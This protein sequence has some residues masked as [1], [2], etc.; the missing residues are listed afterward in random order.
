MCLAGKPIS[1]AVP[2]TFGKKGTDMSKRT[3]LTYDA[4]NVGLMR[5]ESKAEGK[6]EAEREIGNLLVDV[7]GLRDNYPDV[8]TE[9]TRYPKPSE[10][11]VYGRQ[12]GVSYVN[13]ELREG[14]VQFIADVRRVSS[15]DE[16]NAARE[17]LFPNGRDRDA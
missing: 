11:W 6:R 1:I 9:E 5:A 17:R 2:H 12:L 16:F 3:D 8:K 13:V 4:H 15:E 7:F 10:P 14:Y